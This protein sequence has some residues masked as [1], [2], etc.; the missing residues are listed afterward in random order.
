MRDEGSR[1]DGLNSPESLRT[2]NIAGHDLDNDF[3]PATVLYSRDQLLDTAKGRKRAPG[4]DGGLQ[5]L[6][7]ARF[8]GRA[9]SRSRRRARTISLSLG[10]FHPGTPVASKQQGSVSAYQAGNP[11][12]FNENLDI[13]SFRHL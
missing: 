7:S 5:L 8:Q 11:F 6:R 12:Y 1:T 3:G 9:S 10:Q 13:E 2:Q 4:I